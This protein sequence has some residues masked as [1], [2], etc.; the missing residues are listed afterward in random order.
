MTAQQDIPQL[1]EQLY[2]A[3]NQPDE[4]L[5]DSFPAVEAL[6]SAIQTALSH[7]GPSGSSH[8]AAVS[9]RTARAGAAAL[10]AGDPGQQGQYAP[11]IAEARTAEPQ[12]Q[13]AGQKKLRRL[14][15]P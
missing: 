2:Q 3:L 10:C 1:L 7:S 8:A 5:D 11:R 15:A 14:M 4:L 12:T 9:G 13:P 6:S